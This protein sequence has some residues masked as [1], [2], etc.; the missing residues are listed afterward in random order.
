VTCFKLSGRER[1]V[2]MIRDLVRFYRKA[3]D[4]AMAGAASLDCYAD[5][6]AELRGRWVREK[7]KRVDLLMDRAD[8][9]AA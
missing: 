3:I 7:S 8:R 2:A 9:Y 5:E 1:P 6:L 4:A